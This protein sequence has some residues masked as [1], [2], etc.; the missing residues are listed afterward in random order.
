MSKNNQ[1]IWLILQ[2][3]FLSAIVTRSY[4]GGF[5]TIFP[6]MLWE[7]HNVAM[8]LPGNKLWATTC[9]Q[10]VCVHMQSVCVNSDWM[11]C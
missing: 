5:R 11:S 6:M 4:F 9:F 3:D 2:N 8:E 1:I 7:K 10:S